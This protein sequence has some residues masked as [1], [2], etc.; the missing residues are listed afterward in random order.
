MADVFTQIYKL[1]TEADTSGLKKLG[2]D[3]KELASLFAKLKDGMSGI[4]TAALKIGSQAGRDLRPMLEKVEQIQAAINALTQTSAKQKVSLG[5]D[6]QELSSFQKKISEIRNALSAQVGGQDFASKFV[7]SVLKIEGAASVAVK[8]VEAIGVAVQKAL[9][10]ANKLSQKTGAQQAAQGLANKAAADFSARGAL[11][12]FISEYQ[13]AGGIILNVGKA[14]KFV[15]STFKDLGGVLNSATIPEI[16]KLLDLYV[17][18]QKQLGGVARE[19]VLVSGEQRKAAADTRALALSQQLF[20][21]GS[22]SIE[23]AQAAYAKLRVIL[24]ETVADQTR[25]AQIVKEVTA[26]V[27]ASTVALE[28]FT[29]QQKAAN[30][31][32]KRVATL[33]SKDAYVQSKQAL[34][35]FANSFGLI[36]RVGPPV[37]GIIRRVALE[38]AKFGGDLA[39]A[40]ERLKQEIQLLEQ[41]AKVSER[42]AA[43]KAASDR[44]RKFGQDIA[45][46]QQRANVESA[47]SQAL[48]RR[49]DI[50]AL[51]ARNSN[52]LSNIISKATAETLKNNRSTE[53]AIK[54]ANEMANAAIREAEALRGVVTAE[55]KQ[56]AVLAKEELIKNNRNM[57]QA[58]GI[59][60]NYARTVD[61]STRAQLNWQQVAKEFAKVLPT[62]SNDI[63]EQERVL[64]ALVTRMKEFTKLPG[65]MGDRGIISN[66]GQLY[67]LKQ[68]V[69]TVTG[70][71]GASLQAFRDFEDRLIEVRKTASASREEMLALGN[72]ILKIGQ[73]T[74]VPVNDLAEIAGILGQLGVLQSRPGQ[75]ATAFAQD[76]AKAIE[77]IGQVV[78]ATSLSK[79]DAAETYGQIATVFK[80]DVENVR[81]QLVLTTGASADATDAIR[82]MFGAMN[83]LANATLATEQDIRLFLKNFGGVAETA[84]LAYETI[85]ALSGAVANIGLS[86]QVAGTALS[87]LFGDATKKAEVFADALGITTEA[88]K[89]LFFTKPDEALLKFLEALSKASKERSDQIMQGLSAEQRFKNVLLGLANSYQDLRKNIETVSDAQRNYNSIGREAAKFS[90]TFSSAVVRLQNNFVG[91]SQTLSPAFKTLQGILEFLTKT[92]G[93]AIE[94][95]N[96]LPSPIK[97]VITVWGGLVAGVTSV[98]LSFKILMKTLEFAG[99][100]KSMLSLRGVFGVLTLGMST[101][102]LRLQEFNANNKVAAESA[103]VAAASIETQAVATNQLAAAQARQQ[104]AA[105]G[106]ASSSKTMATAVLNADKATAGWKTRLASLGGGLTTAAI[107]VSALVSGISSFS[108][109]NVLSGVLESLI[110]IASAA[111]SVK[112]LAGG[113]T[114]VGAATV[115]SAA[116]LGSLAV[117]AGGALAL[118]AKTQSMFSDMDATATRFATNTQTWTDELGRAFS[119]MRASIQ[120]GVADTLDVLGAHKLAKIFRQEKEALDVLNEQ[121]AKKRES[122]VLS[123]QLLSAEIQ[124]F[125][126]VASV[127]GTSVASVKDTVERL[128]KGSLALIDAYAALNDSIERNREAFSRGLGVITTTNTSLQDQ[129]NLVNDL[130]IA[131]TKAGKSRAEVMGGLSD[132]PI[133]DTQRKFVEGEIARVKG[134]IEASLGNIDEAAKKVILDP[135]HT[136]EGALADAIKRGIVTGYK[137]VNGKFVADIAAKQADDVLFAQQQM[138]DLAEQRKKRETEI[139]SVIEQQNT[140]QNQAHN[141]ALLSEEKL[142][143]LRRAINKGDTE[144]IKNVDSLLT[145]YEKEIAATKIRLAQEEGFSVKFEQQK[146]LLT[147][148]L[149]STEQYIANLKAMGASSDLVNQAEIQRQ[150]TLTTLNIVEQ[151]ILLSTKGILAF[152]KKLTATVEERNK[153]KAMAVELAI[154]EAD[155]IREANQAELLSLNRE[156]LAAMSKIA[157]KAKP[158]VA[159]D[160]DTSLLQAE[161]EQEMDKLRKLR[162]IDE[163]TLQKMRTAIIAK[164]T[165]QQQELVVG[166]IENTAARE[167]KALQKVLKLNEQAKKD[168]LEQDSFTVKSLEFEIDVYKRQIASLTTLDSALKKIRASAGEAF[169]TTLALDTFNNKVQEISDNFLAVRQAVKDLGTAFEAD[170]GEAARKSF[171]AIRKSAFDAGRSIAKTAVEQGRLQAT[172]Q[173]T[174][175]TQKGKL[176][177]DFLQQ[178]R[179]VFSQQGL[180]D[181]QRGFI[182]QRG[183]EQFKERFGKMQGKGPAL[184]DV[185][186][187]AE[188]LISV[189]GG[190]LKTEQDIT[191][192][193]SKQ[194]SL[195]ANALNMTTEEAKELQKVLD[196]RIQIRQFQEQLKSGAV[197]PNI[198]TARPDVIQGRN[199]QALAELAL[200]K[201]KEAGPTDTR[202]RQ[203]RTVAL[204][205]AEFKL[206]DIRKKQNEDLQQFALVEE[207]VS[208]NL[209]ALKTKF[210]DLAESVANDMNPTL[211]SLIQSISRL[212]SLSSGDAVAGANAA[213]TNS[214][215]NIQQTLSVT[216]IQEPIAQILKPTL[217]KL[218]ITSQAMVTTMTEAFANT[219]RVTGSVVNSM[220]TISERAKQMSAEMQRLDAT[221]QRAVKE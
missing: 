40:T 137:S 213:L 133:T 140:L 217:D 221:L 141:D 151:D 204:T 61:R 121:I 162:F 209:E 170:L 14:Q 99:I 129:W 138:F 182:V 214:L 146:K 201:I 45:A 21:S 39:Y 215:S 66:L 79:Q 80:Q 37:Q 110:G 19:Q 103:S 176:A 30:E 8:S 122:L 177:T 48:L 131:Y 105:L 109:G 9:Q 184:E 169:G 113:I 3:A 116:A 195:V 128:E 190:K 75:T 81:R 89:T 123:K 70:S 192:E 71:F 148:Q 73:T 108:Q 185:L 91:L 125:S 12:T 74:A 126:T 212:A 53:D 202:E 22:L 161:F 149:A 124:A 36:E 47:I 84:G 64:T 220:N 93:L 52:A 88:W 147:D 174:A 106:A 186:A 188:Q 17:Q 172:L 67:L 196:R 28:Q 5:I 183:I 68:V 156:N 92:L 18:T 211:D 159:F 135:I 130:T 206:L 98:I 10:G 112:L 187:V 134:L 119:K 136:L 139:N 104:S 208:A 179:S 178:L 51:L 163:E 83:E 15:E 155:K 144:A 82:S 150:K 76:A 94:A 1:V 198:L 25:E 100:T 26:S 207:T 95:F 6:P 62:I 4:G 97:N 60:N 16:K 142:L 54:L 210:T 127:R 219:A 171:D 120:S 46:L 63:R 72:S 87:R 49:S 166:L 77:L 154:K 34:I 56:A 57:A 145:Y 200:S 38:T 7:G 193:M 157:K 43:A 181:E 173:S 33:F 118:L 23:Q 41:D 199:E 65:S 153:A 32:Q 216:K 111:S 102:I 27:K 42:A 152:E 164:Y 115:A 165:A 191:S 194:E 218:D 58:A 203:D 55:E 13:K 24:R 180:T 114:G 29:V 96:S 167:E 86:Q 197:S 101:A 158:S 69:D 2:T 143:E 160:I 85:L 59:V 117:A 31:Q 11:Q 175:G 50:E 168:R 90:E 78:Q 35:D 205:E 107:G 189:E 132:A 44:S 20:A